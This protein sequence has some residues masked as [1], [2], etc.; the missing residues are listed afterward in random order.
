MNPLISI[1]IPVYNAEK[2]LGRIITAVLNQTYQNFELILINDGST[3]DSH[4][5]CSRYA[6]SDKRIRYYSQENH[7]AGYT[8]A[9]GIEVASGEFIAFADTDDYM[10]PDMYGVMLNAILKEDADVCACQ[11]HLELTNGQHVIDHKIYGDTFYGVKTGVEFAEYLYKYREIEKGGY[12]YANGVVVSPWNK[13]YKK[14]I[15][16]GF[17]TT[18]YLGEDEEMNDYA[19][20][21]LQGG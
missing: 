17:Q 16:Q 13:L 1:I 8:R 20:S 7:G 19:L 14:S 3:D 15:L 12:G 21:Q 4:S 10:T 6:A 2:F 5:I 11:W 18:G 9:R